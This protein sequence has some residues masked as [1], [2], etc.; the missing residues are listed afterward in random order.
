[1]VMALG[2]RDDQAAAIESI[3]RALADGRLDA[4]VLS[5]AEARL[6]VLAERFPAGEVPYDAAKRSADDVLMHRG[7]AAGLTA[8]NGPR[9]PRPDQK[10]RVFTQGKVPCD[11]VS[12]AGLPV[13]EVTRLFD[14]FAHADVVAVDDLQALTSQQLKADGVF[15]VLVSNHRD[16]YRAAAG[17]QPDL[18][19]ALWNPFQVLDVAAPAVVTWGY[20]DGAL[21]ALKAWLIGN[22]G[23]PGHAPVCLEEVR[24]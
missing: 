15:T 6:D 16:R 7:W 22:T 9:P 13:E 2:P 5:R 1:M 3:A 19:L 21:N 14:G 8:V 4:A 18:H 17:W 20:A 24:A 11:G 12:E 10:V 23:T